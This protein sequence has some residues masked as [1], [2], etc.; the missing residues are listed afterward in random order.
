[1]KVDHYAITLLKKHVIY[2]VLFAGLVAF[3]FFFVP[4]KLNE[5]REFSEKQESLRA[6]VNK[7][8][9]KSSLLSRYSSSQVDELVNVV[10]KLL[11]DEYTVFNVYNVLDDFQ[12]ASGLKFVTT[13]NPFSSI[14]EE[15]ATISVTAEGSNNSILNLLENY[16]TVGGRMADIKS[17]EFKPSTSTISFI[18]TLYAEKPATSS[19][20]IIPRLDNSSITLLQKLYAQ[21]PQTSQ[22]D[23]L[24]IPYTGGKQ[25]PFQ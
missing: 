6:E 17:F 10:Q 19:S 21:S 1:M 5:Y 20:S 16:Q 4:Q 3:S 23:I 24:P 7:L 9:E 11:P 8:S 18:L 13:S 2:I 25:N 14:S 12:R 15:G 22:I